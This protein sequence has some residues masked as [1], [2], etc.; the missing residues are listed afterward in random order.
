MGSRAIYLIREKGKTMGFS[1]YQGA[2]ALSPLLR[3]YQA[4]EIQKS[5]PEPN[6]ITHI[7]GH[8][9]Y[10]GNYRNPRLADEDMFAA[11]LSPDEL[12]TYNAAYKKGSL[13]EMR[14]LFELDKN[15]FEMEYNPNCPWYRTMGVYSID[16]DA[17]LNNV[18]KLLTHA[19]ECG[20]SDFGRLLTIYNNSTGLAEKLDAARDSM[21][22]EEYLN[23]PQAQEDRERY[24]RLFGRQEDLDNE[25]MEEQ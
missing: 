6:S 14:M 5:L 10:G 1:V 9:D 21:R 20:I 13:I 15:V 22:V 24:W 2:N 18:Q 19:E 4:K 7:F 23:S 8:L 25:E 12:R 11:Y 17:G 16:L 3:L